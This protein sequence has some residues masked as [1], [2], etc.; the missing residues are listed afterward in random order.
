M[1]VTIAESS[2]IALDT[3]DSVGAS[4]RGS[5]LGSLLASGDVLPPWAFELLPHAIVSFFAFALG[6]CLGS[7][8]NVLIVR[9]PEG[10][11]V[12]SPPSRCPVCG[13]RLGW[14]ENLPVVG[15]LLL[16]GRCRAC[17]VAI[18]PQYL[19]LEIVCGLLLVWV[20]LAHFATPAYATWWSELGGIWWHR[21]GPLRALPAATVEA[22]L[23][24][25]LIV[26]TKI[27]ARTFTIP[28]AIPNAVVISALLLW[29]V[30][31]LGPASRGAEGLW[32][33]P[34]LGWPGALA[35]F[36]GFAGVLLSTALLHWRVIRPSFADYEEYLADLPEGAGL[37][38]APLREAA[39]E[40][41][42]PARDL[43]IELQ[44]LAPPLASA[45]AGLWIAGARTASVCCAAL[46]AAAL[47]GP[48]A[49]LRGTA[50]VAE[51]APLAEEYP[52][53]RR[54]MLREL[55]F[56]LPCLLGLAVGWLIGTQL[57][58]HAVDAPAIGGISSALSASIAG[59]LVGGGLVWGVRILATM[60]FGREAMGLGDVHLLAAVGAA[61][62][63]AAPV[64]AF[65][66]APF[67]GLAWIAAS[68]LLG[69]R[70]ALQQGSLPYGPHLAL[71]AAAAIALAPALRPIEASLVEAWRVLAG[72]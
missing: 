41:S 48:I 19:L 5:G 39:P 16:R 23:L 4:P 53:A 46:A 20:Y 62:G 32:P 30:Q 11:S 45:A 43:P 63:V 36:G 34:T 38:S 2:R 28:M 14:R 59:Y 35:A 13:V 51:E 69:G 24:V 27:D 65:F 37:G 68:R 25:G 52:H 31:A 33:I 15:W 18:S 9:M 49:W 6:A 71:G 8:A 50:P 47:L 44:F 26:M 12:V 70:G 3:L 7:F 60:A 22:I 64:A 61:A 56:L 40:D 58:L 10:I 57:E 55:L 29:S 42:Q 67:L 1:P 21:N 17:G 72:G 54:E 66:I